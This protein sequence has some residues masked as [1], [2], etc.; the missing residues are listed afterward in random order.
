MNRLSLAGLVLLLAAPVFAATAPAPPQTYGESIDVRVVN[1]EAVVTDRRGNR[2]EGLKAADFR[3]LVDGREVPVDYFTEVVGGVA[4]APAAA[5]GSE[6][7][8]SAV[9]VGPG[10]KVG[11][12]YLVFVDDQFSIGAPRDL[13]LRRLAAD[14]GRLGPQDRM[15]IV[16]FDGNQLVRL[17]DWTADHQA[18]AQAFAAEEKRPSYGIGKLAERRSEGGDGLEGQSLAALIDQ[19][20]NQGIGVQAVVAAMRGTPAPAGRKVMVLLNGGWGVPDVPE[21]KGALPS[22]E[23]LPEAKTLFAPIFDTANLLGY[24]IYAVDVQGLDPDSTW[25]DA[26]AAGPSEHRFITTGFER[27][28]HEALEVVARETGGKAILNSARLDA[29]ARVAADT[30]AYYWL[31]F[32]PQW[33]ADGSR[34]DVRLE[35]R[36]PGLAVRSRTGF[37]DLTREQEAQVQAAGQLLYGGSPVEPLAVTAGTSRRSGWLTMEM[38]LTVEIPVS[39]LTPMPA[40]GGWSLAANLSIAAMEGGAAS[41]KWQTLPVRIHVAELPQKAGSLRWE[42]LLKLKRS[43]R[44]LL[45]VLGADTGEVLRKTQLAVARPAS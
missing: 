26:S 38:P 37:S 32:T 6:A 13:V 10:E 7:P 12:N 29:F 34:H 22:A 9:P 33:K 3:L 25:A 39:A 15:A 36:R 42:T 23:D 35:V 20:W 1:V 4:A 8:A 18:L 31:G 45:V 28:V 24:T 27:G 19:V 11:T 14:L 43:T 17:S 30:N 21:R 16:S 40:E 2:V 41:A 5:S 44:Q